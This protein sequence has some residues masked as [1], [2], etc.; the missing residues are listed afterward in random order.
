MST[1]ISSTREHLAHLDADVMVVERYGSGEEITDAAAL[2]I[3]SRWDAPS[4]PGSEFGQ[5]AGT[6][7]VDYHALNAAIADVFEQVLREGVV[8]VRALNMLATWAMNHPTRQLDGTAAYVAQ[9]PIPPHLIGLLRY[10]WVPLWS[11][12]R[13]IGWTSGEVLRQDVIDSEPFITVRLRD[14][15]EAGYYAYSIGYL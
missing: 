11:G 8:S 7:M 1:L 9:N 15:H 13:V 12:G 4:G 6:G 3:A 2:T 14:G 10:V 5:L